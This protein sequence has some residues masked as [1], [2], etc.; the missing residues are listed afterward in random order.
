[1]KRGLNSGDMQKNNRTTVFRI[2]L[3]RGSMSRTQL[4]A[5]VGLQKATITNI[6]NGF[7]SMGIVD[8]D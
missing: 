8:V 4:S 5:E 6:I 3:E 7:I 2:L 1:M